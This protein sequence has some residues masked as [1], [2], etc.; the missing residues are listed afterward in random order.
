MATSCLSAEQG[1]KNC[2]AVTG[3]RCELWL[4]SPRNEQHPGVACTT[5]LIILPYSKPE[6]YLLLLQVLIQIET[7]N[8]TVMAGMKTEQSYRS[9]LQWL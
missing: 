3:G 2:S 5:V 6:E 1:S 4:P 7:E 9:D 8:F